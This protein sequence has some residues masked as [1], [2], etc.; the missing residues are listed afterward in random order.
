MANS[1]TGNPWTIDT[2]GVI[3]TSAV[4][5]K[6]L[7]WTNATDGDTLV[8]LDNAGRDIIRAKYLAAGD[9]NFGE[10]RWVQGFNVTTIGSGEVT[11]VIHK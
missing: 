6:N 10:F 4:F 5:I 3:T 8:I 2:A 1:I 9:N 11:V 7:L